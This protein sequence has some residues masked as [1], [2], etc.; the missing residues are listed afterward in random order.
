MNRQPQRVLRKS[1]TRP[2]PS[3]FS[4]SRNQGRNEG[5]KIWSAASRPRTT[6]QPPRHG[7]DDGVPPSRL[8]RRPRGST[9]GKGWTDGCASDHSS[10]SDS[11]GGAEIERVVKAATKKSHVAAAPTKSNASS[12]SKE[13]EHAVQ[14]NA[15][16]R[17]SLHTA[18][19][20]SQSSQGTESMLD[21]AKIPEDITS[22][23]QLKWYRQRLFHVEERTRERLQPCRVLSPGEAAKWRRQNKDRADEGSNVIQYLTF[24]NVEKGLYKCADDGSLIPIGYVSKDGAS[25]TFNDDHL[26][27]YMQQESKRTSARNLEN[28]RLFIKKA[29]DHARESQKRSR[30]QAK[31]DLRDYLGDSGSEE[32][33]DEPSVKASGRRRVQFFDVVENAGVDNDDDDD[34][35]NIDMEDLDVPYTQAITFDPDDFGTGGDRSDEPIRPGDVIEYYSPIFV[36]GDPRGQRHATVLTVKADEDS[37]L[38][39]S[40]GE[41]I[42]DDTKVKRI[43][44]KSGDELLD[45]PGIYRPISRFK[46]IYGGS[47]TAADAIAM[48]ASRFGAIMNK[49]ISKAREKAEADGFAPMD[50]LVKVKG[51]NTPGKQSTSARRHEKR[52]T[53]SQYESSANKKL[54]KHSKQTTKRMHESA[55]EMNNKENNGTSQESNRMSSGSLARSSS[56]GSSLASSDDSEGGVESTRHWNRSSQTS[57][58][59]ATNAKPILNVDSLSSLASSSASSDVSDDEELAPLDLGWNHSNV[60]QNSVRRGGKEARG[61]SY[62]GGEDILSLSSEDGSK[63]NQPQ[64]ARRGSR[65]TP[66]KSTP[67]SA[68]RSPNNSSDSESSPES[69]KSL[70]VRKK[71]ATGMSSRN[72][73]M[74][75]SKRGLN[76]AAS[77][78]RK[79]ASSPPS[80]SVGKSIP[81]SPDC[82]SSGSTDSSSESSAPSPRRPLEK[83]V[84][85]MAVPSKVLS[86]C[87][88]GSRGAMSMTVCIPTTSKP[89][90]N[91]KASSPQSEED[92]YNGSVP[93]ESTTR[94]EKE[95]NKGLSPLTGNNDG[96]SSSGWTQVKLDG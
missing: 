56:S 21:Q 77:K 74:G 61:K 72:S 90:K 43:K 83:E 93:I 3:S 81:D 47:A 16:S 19:T 53:P 5:G 69:P 12:R 71:P 96:I 87:P 52:T 22:V 26:R 39:L 42:P 58:K 23:A 57:S 30:Q 35:S 60:T 32:S 25:A 95:Y 62:R 70:G 8:D 51:V 92:S 88:K 7:N 73:A 11:E 14:T 50:L 86:K 45:H 65:E 20:H 89:S 6:G 40:N 15:K 68:M 64:K 80:S 94:T 76:G 54:A 63:S 82:S 46:L 17:S 67:L 66:S 36:A 28:M 44:V 48:E 29:F 31:K 55:S 9:H 37:S 10:G 85:K 2:R 75:T 59:L 38:V 24:P 78:K 33:G 13:K 34:E 4:G 41:V 91:N 79:A 1:R 18:R 27:R 49:N 84:K